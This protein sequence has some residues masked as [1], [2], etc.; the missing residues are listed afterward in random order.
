MGIRERQTAQQAYDKRSGKGI[1]GT[2]RIHHIDGRC[3]QCGAFVGGEDAAA[4]FALGK[5]NIGYAESLHQPAALL[6]VAA[7]GKSD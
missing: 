6:F 7:V 5:Y 1:T 2:D 4:F 3:R